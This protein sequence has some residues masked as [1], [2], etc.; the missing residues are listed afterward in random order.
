MALTTPILYSISA[1]DASQ[2]ATFTFNSVGGSQVVANTLTIKNNATLATVYSKTQTTFQFQH[3]V[4]AGTLTN[5]TYYQATLTTQDADGNVSNVSNPIQF[6]CYTT[7]TF[8]ISNMPS[9]NVITNASFEFNVTYNQIQGEILNAYIFNLYSATGS[10]ISTSSTQYNTDTT[11]P[12]TISWL[13]SGMDDKAT[14]SIEV[15]GV[16]TEGTQITTGKILFV[17]NYVGPSTYSALY[18]TNN[19]NGGYITIESNVVGIDGETSPETPTYIDGKEIDLRNDGDYVQWADGYIINGDFTMRLWGRNFNPNTE[20]LKFANSNGDNITLKYCTNATSC[21]W[22]LRVV[23]KGDYWGYV[24]G[25]DYIALPDDD[26]EVFCWLR[27]I[28]NIYELK[29]ENRGVVS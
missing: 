19:C 16:T 25:S 8:V 15:N 18:L 7:P 13:F 24:I 21:W 2:I 10:L 17:C 28:G 5:G 3:T 12:L 23:H 11:L 4:P 27:R 22:E 14:Y 1:F 6:Y 9:S 26:E 29:T 20:I